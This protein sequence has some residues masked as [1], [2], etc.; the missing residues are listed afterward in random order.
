MANLP[1]LQ[2]Y[3]DGSWPTAGSLIVHVRALDAASTDL[4]TLAP[5]PSGLLTWL[6]AQQQVVG[7]GEA[8]RIEVQGDHAI[9]EASAQWNA[10]VAGAHVTNDSPYE[11][12][13]R[14]PFALGS[15]GSTV[16][17]EARAAGAMTVVAAADPAAAA[18]ALLKNRAKFSACLV[19]GS[20]GMALAR[21]VNAFV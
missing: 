17:R 7:W 20:R 1:E 6:G 21:L 11:W 19:K 16:C 4:L 12:A 14:A 5:E 18:E 3:A 2:G 15:F 9:R 8:A 13:N 10:L